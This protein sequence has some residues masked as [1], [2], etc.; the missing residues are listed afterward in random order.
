MIVSTLQL[1]GTDEPD[2][3]AP[4]EI[5]VE[6][7]IRPL[8][9]VP[10]V[11]WA[12]VFL[13]VAAILL[14]L[15]VAYALRFGLNLLSLGDRHAPNS[16][17]VLLSEILWSCAMFVALYGNRLYD[18]DTLIPSGAQIGRVTR[19]AMEATAVFAIVVFLL[20]A[21]D[22]SRG[23]FL[24]VVLLTVLLLASE[25]TALGRFVGHQQARGNLR[26]EAVLVTSSDQLPT[27][28]VGDQSAEFTIIRT[29]SPEAFLHEHLDKEVVDRS[30][31]IIVDDD[32]LIKADLWRLVVKAGN[33]G[34]STF[35]RTRLPPLSQDRLAARE[36]WGQSII[37]VSPPTLLGLRSMEKRCF[38]F[39]F[40]LLALAV[41]TPV[42]TLLI[43]GVLLLSGRP[44]FYKQLRVGRRGEVF[45]MWKF[46][47]M[48]RD[49]EAATGPVFALT[50]DDRRTTIGKFL[51]RSSLDE[52][53]Q[54]WNV[55]KGD[56][57]IVGP[58]PERPFFVSQY[59]AT[60]PWYQYRHRIRP[61]LTGLSQAN[62]LRGNT[63]L[64][65]RVETDNRYIEHWSLWLDI[66]I[67]AKTL[68]E[69]F[70]G[71]NAY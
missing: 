29:I 10:I 52:L 62:G 66:G 28:A 50:H 36:L 7:S 21:D 23:W 38:D 4:H 58:R 42:F 51:R 53:P 40:S 59:S 18:E 32:H 17:A 11:T 8:H 49:A 27:S 57:S 44:V 64:P 2:V 56:M 13:D 41:L 45:M 54:L 1:R 61:G 68:R 60:L 15:S 48:K 6:S 70:V 35:L 71:R 25:R 34:C 37:K 20:R 3:L 24:W 16:A 19:A 5:P 67:I 47:T 12:R 31:V 14:A 65:E 69:I 39:V 26:R 63:S 22:D 30:S 46:R 33:L 43:L 9:R 55:L